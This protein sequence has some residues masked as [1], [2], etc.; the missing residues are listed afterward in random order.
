MFTLYFI[1]VLAFFIGLAIFMSTS[2]SMIVTTPQNSEQEEK[3]F[4]N[5]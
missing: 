5:E 4:D 3:G 2:D 1:F